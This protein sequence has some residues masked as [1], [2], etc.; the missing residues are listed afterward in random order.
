M[1]VEEIDYINVPERAASLGCN[2]PTGI[3]LLP[4]NFDVAV[5]KRDLIHE[6]SVPTVRTLWREAGINETKLEQDDERYPQISEKGLPEWEGPTV[7]VT[8]AWLSQN[9]AAFSIALGVISN[10]V[11]E[12]FLGLNNHPSRLLKNR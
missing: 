12:I 1:E 5:E 3:A 10:Y 7:L 6:S 9:P 2:V 8:F 11:T 4:R